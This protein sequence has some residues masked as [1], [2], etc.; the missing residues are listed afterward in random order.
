M[1]CGGSKQGGNTRP[2]GPN[3]NLQLARGNPGSHVVWGD[4]LSSD[5]RAILAT[6]KQVNIPY[7]FRL[8][9]T[10]KGENKQDSYIQQSFCDVIPMVSNDQFKVFGGDQ[11]LIKY[12]KFA[13]PE[14]RK[15][16]YSK[17][18][19]ATIEKY[20]GWFN[21]KMRPDTQ[22]LIRMIVLPKV[23]STVAVK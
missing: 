11:A 13:F 7:E 3:T 10:L 21:S 2:G 19:E 5:T 9:D 4:Y 17:E 1:G 12:S 6:F 16:L 20:I 22:R 23:V 15:D 18:M 8:V 14:V